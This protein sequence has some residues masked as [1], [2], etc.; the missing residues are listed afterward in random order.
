[1][2]ETDTPY[3]ETPYLHPV[4]RRLILCKT[5]RSIGQGIMLVDLALF[6]KDLDWSATSI[7]GILTAS[8][9]VSIALV[10]FVG[11]LSD[12][13]G[14]KPFLLFYEIMTA[15]CALIG[16]VTT[17]PILL[18][19]AIALTGFGR[20]QTGSPGPFAPAEQAWL[21]A[22]VPRKDRGN[23]Y[24]LNNA[25][26]FFGMAAG[27]LL[28]G[29]TVFWDQVLPGALAYRP[30]FALILV[31]SLATMIIIATTKGEKVERPPKIQNEQ[32][33][34]REKAITRSEN[35]SILKLVSINILNGIAVGLTGPMISYWFAVKF[36]VTNAQIGTTLAIT[37]FVTGFASLFQ[38][39]LSN[40]FGMVR[41]VMWMRIIGSMLMVLLPILPTYVLVSGVYVLRSAINRG[42]QGA[43]QALSVSLTR[44]K[45]RGFAS[46]IFSLSMRVPTSAGPYVTGYLFELGAL[47]I[48]FYA[49]AVLQFGYA[50]LYGR[51]FRSY[52]N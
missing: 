24:S 30:L 13:I 15:A 36:G 50:Y 20:G 32:T 1:M 18:S 8:G 43:R 49:A 14:R 48:P 9:F 6:L 5:L 4:A 31:L 21:A 38:A 3:E 33:R 45:R 52:D 44:D 39:K 22:Y 16:V 10:L 46:S 12:R 51:T 41:S 28:A 34:N 7:G 26:G 27:A 23:V 37:Y 25:C 17:N 29:A 19:I 2:A 47:S 42:T 40:Q 35:L 11:V